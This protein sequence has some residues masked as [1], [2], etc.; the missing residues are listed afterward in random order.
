MYKNNISLRTIN[1]YI[2]IFFLLLYLIP[3]SVFSSSKLTITDN[4]STYN[5]FK[6]DYHMEKS[7]EA[8]GIDKISKLPFSEQ[9][10]N[11]FSFGYKENNFWFHLSIHNDSHKSKEMVLEITEI[12]HKTVDLYIISDSVN[13]IQNGL[14]VPITS[15]EIEE[16]NPAFK[17]EFEPD[18]TKELYINISTIY[19]AFGSI[20]LKTD[21]QFHKDVQ[22][23]KYMY[24]IY[25]T[26]II[27]IGLYNLIIFF[28]LR[29]KVYLYYIGYVFVFVLWVANYK[30]VFLPYI[31]IH[32]YDFL[33]ITIPIFFNMLILFSQAILG[34]KKFF[35]IF[36]K[37]LNGFL[38]ILSISLGWMLIDLHSG[39]YFMNI[40]ASPLLPFLLFVAIWAL[41]NRHKVA[42]LY[43]LALTIYLISMFLISQLALGIL[44]YNIILS[45]A[46]II[47]SFFEIIFFSF[48]LSY[49]INILREEKL[50]TQEKLY[51]KEHDESVRLAQMVESQTSS[52]LATKKALE[53]ELEERKILEKDLLFQASTDSL[54]GIMNR[55]SFF[56]RCSDTLGQ[57]IRYERDLSLLILDLDHFKNVNEKYGHLGGDQALIQVVNRIKESI[58][59]TDILGRIGGEEFALLMPETNLKSAQL[60]A[61]RI[62]KDIGNLPVDIDGEV[63]HVTVSIGVDTLEEEDTTIQTV[64]RRSDLALF[65]AKENG[66]NQVCCH[67]EA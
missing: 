9:I 43:L 24:L 19:G 38:I 11:S 30:G 41:Y 49:R 61:E 3:S 62:R 34:T 2:T 12:I 13:H 57:A 20:Q 28:Y 44:P 35:P 50:K 58:R 17:L 29:E 64:L 51:E 32:M 60:L 46:P 22:F 53:K 16:S 10:S 6:V 47:G 21:T 54:T 25:L 23:K 63:M 36:H 40:C 56:V 65:Q 4:I 27:I 5:N 39:F 55:R 52:L 31:N 59:D 18:E 7:D 14:S 42:K 45:H 67:D 26:A 8:L 48:L 1:N 37:I 33:Q 66:R 15:R